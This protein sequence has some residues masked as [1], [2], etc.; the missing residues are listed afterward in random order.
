MLELL[1]AAHVAQNLHHALPARVLRKAKGARAQINTIIN[2]HPLHS[3]LRQPL[4]L[5]RPILRNARFAP[6]PLCFGIGNIV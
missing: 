5:V 6:T 1:Q 2:K 4:S 3:I